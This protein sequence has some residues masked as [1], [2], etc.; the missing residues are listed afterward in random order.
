M[1]VNYDTSVS[2]GIPV[3]DDGNE[4]FRDSHILKYFLQKVTLYSVECF[5][6]VNEAEHSGQVELPIFLGK[7]SNIGYLLWSPSSLDKPY[8][9][10]WYFPF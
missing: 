10:A 4:K 8:M 5:E 6:V 9:F 7:G 3:Y 1:G 2:F